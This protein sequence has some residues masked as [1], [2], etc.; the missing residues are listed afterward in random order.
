MMKPFYKLSIK[1]ILSITTTPFFVFV[2]IEFN[3]LAL[4][5]LKLAIEVLLLDI[6][7][8]LKLLENK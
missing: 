2:E 3:G 4:E 5:G 1:P 6:E 8:K 7:N